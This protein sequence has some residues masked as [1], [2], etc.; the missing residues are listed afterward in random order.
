M[1]IQV[2]SGTS[3]CNLLTQYMDFARDITQASS[4]TDEY[5]RLRL[6]YTTVVYSNVILLFYCQFSCFFSK[7]EKKYRPNKCSNVLQS[8]HI[9]SLARSVT[10]KTELI[11]TGNTYTAVC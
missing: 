6:Q 11:L 1:M 10:V 9:S 2:I 5:N 3:E 8:R 7:Q 4:I